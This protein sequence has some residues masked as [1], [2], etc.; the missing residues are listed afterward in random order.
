MIDE[1]DK[2]VK[3]GN[4]LGG[5]FKVI[6][7]NVIPGL[8]S[9][10][11]WDKRLDSFLS[12]AVMSVPA[13]KGVEI[14]AGFALS[15]M[16]GSKAQDEIFYNPKEQRFY[17]KT[18]FAGGL[19]GGIT[20][21]EDIVIS[22]V[23]KPIPTLMNPLSSIDVKTKKTVKAEIIRSDAC[24]VP[25]CSVVAEAMVAYVLANAIMEKFGGD[26]IREVTVNYKNYIK[27]TKNF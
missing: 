23:M 6:V 27:Q 16:T 14:G 9:H 25:A 11:Q 18:N 21:G 17:R 26:S 22:A 20:N 1:I 10:I 7:K 19:E 12:A 5:T 13:I 2:A 4:T 8:G 24:A 3:N 15:G